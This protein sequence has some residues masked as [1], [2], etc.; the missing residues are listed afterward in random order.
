[1]TP[2]PTT[3]VLTHGSDDASHRLSRRT[4]IALVGAGLALVLGFSAWR[5]WP[6][7][8]PVFALVD[9]QGVYAGMVRSDGTNEASVIN[10]GSTTAEPGD[11][12]PVACSPLFEATVLN[13]PPREA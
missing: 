13:R 6:G 8:P 10:P 7:P 9:L 12:V 4:L 2:P 11:V 5:L 1:M 3:D